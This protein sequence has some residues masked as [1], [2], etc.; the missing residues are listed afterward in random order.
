[1][2]T[3]DSLD[4]PTETTRSTPNRW[5]HSPLFLIASLLLV[6]LASRLDVVAPPLGVPTAILVILV[7]LR[8]S[9]ERFV[10]LGFE[11]PKSWTK[12]FLLG[13]VL[14]LGAQ[15]FATLIVLPI[16]QAAGIPLPDFSNFAGV[17]GNLS[18]LLLFLFIGWVPAGFG[19]EIIWRGFFMTRLARLLGESRAAWIASVLGTSIIFGMLHTYQGTGGMILTGTAGVILGT[20]YLWSGRNLWLAIFTHGIM[21]TLSFTALYLGLLQ[22]WFG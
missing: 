15:A 7:L 12:T 6:L 20:I 8:L 16:L 9:G 13:A 2:N 1:M 17:E 14:A 5:S 10:D 21:N 22:R 4:L 3:T 18:A 19:E 11:R